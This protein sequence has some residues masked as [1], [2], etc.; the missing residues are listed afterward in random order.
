MKSYLIIFI[1]VLC[2]TCWLGDAGNPPST[3]P[4]RIG[5]MTSAPY[6]P[7]HQEEMIPDFTYVD[8][9]RNSPFITKIENSSIGHEAEFPIGLR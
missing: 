2:F 4:V 8:Q 6:G 9:P 7:I 1:L 3:V 5:E